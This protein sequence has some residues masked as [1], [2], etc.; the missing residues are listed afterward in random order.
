MQLVSPDPHP[1][2]TMVNPTNYD[3][4]QIVS[5]SEENSFWYQS[6]MD[7]KKGEHN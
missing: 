2:G 4:L 6:N 7:Q 5:V 3:A 1:T